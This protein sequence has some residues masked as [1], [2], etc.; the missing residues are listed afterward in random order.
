MSLDVRLRDCVFLSVIS[1]LALGWYFNCCFEARER[2]FIVQ[3]HSDD[4]ARIEALKQ[5]IDNLLADGDAASHPSLA[6]L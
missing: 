5:T 2:D 1:A 4:A 3:Q 6:E